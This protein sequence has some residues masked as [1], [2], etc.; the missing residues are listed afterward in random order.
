MKYSTHT[1]QK[2]VRM[3]KRE[4]AAVLNDKKEWHVR[5]SQGNKKIGRVMNV[6]TFPILCC[7]NCKACSGYCYDIKACLQYSNVMHARAV[8]TVMA[9]Y[10]RDEYFGQIDAAISRRRKN[11][12]FR[13]HVAG[14]ILDMD[15]FKRMVYI[16]RKHPDFTF[17]T[18]T[19]MYSIVN[20]WI[21]VHG[22]LPFNL[23][24]MFSRWEGMDMDNPHNLPEFRVR[25]EGMSEDPFITL[26]KCP[27]NCDACK[28]GGGRGCI[29]GETSYVD[30]H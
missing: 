25:M 24:V 30:E 27:G 6:S 13:W 19:K 1:K 18:Y 17:W 16:A 9:N 20:D 5:I 21:Y 14:D 2:F 10:A 29:A 28:V 11:K 4:R 15:Y 3:A 23:H 26:H 12:Y 22:R 7:G 8:N